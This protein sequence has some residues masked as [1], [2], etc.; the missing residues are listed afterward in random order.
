MHLAQDRVNAV[1]N[2]GVSSLAASVNFQ[3]ND[4]APHS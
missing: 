2:L 4:F 1:R 3:T